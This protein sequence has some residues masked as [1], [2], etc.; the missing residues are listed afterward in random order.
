[1]GNEMKI[2]I[3][4]RHRITN[5]QLRTEYI[6]YNPNKREPIPNAQKHQPLNKTTYQSHLKLNYPQN[7]LLDR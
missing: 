4:K 2:A 6:V 3:T 1:M 5:Y 7:H